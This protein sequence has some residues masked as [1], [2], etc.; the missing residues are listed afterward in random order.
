MKKLLL[1]AALLASPAYAQTYNT[2][3]LGNGYSTTTDDQGNTYNTVPLGNGYSTTTG[4]DGRT[5]NTV[6]LGNGYSTTNCY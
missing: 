6:P 5:C 2:V 4:S 1:A 3:P